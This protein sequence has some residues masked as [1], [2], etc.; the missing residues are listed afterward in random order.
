MLRHALPAAAPAVTPAPADARRRRSRDRRR[1]PRRGR[2][3]GRRGRLRRLA[4]ATLDANWSTTTR[5][6]RARLYPHQWSWDSAFI[7]I[8]LAQRPPRRAPGGS[9]RAC[10]GAVGRRA[11]AAHRVQPGAAGRRVL[12]RAGVLALGRRRRARRRSPPPASSSRRC[13]R[14]PPGW[15]TGGTRAEPAR[16]RC[17]GSIPRLA[18]QHRYLADRRDLG[19]GGLAAIVHPWESGLDNSPAWDAPMA[20]V[21]AEAAVMRAYR[22]HDTAHADAAHRPTDLDYARYVALVA[23]YR[24]HGYDDRDLAAGTRSWWSARCSTPRSGAAEHALAEIAA[25]DRRRPR[26]APG[27]RGPDHRSPGRRL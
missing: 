17:A 10:S 16:P 15:R 27:P 25:L 14:S 6:P 26:A 9:W 4:V 11:G 19:G 20:A 2:A 1:A 13:T 7:A 3:A 8:G 5:C 18:A 22:R 24:D 23:A 21:P 12:P